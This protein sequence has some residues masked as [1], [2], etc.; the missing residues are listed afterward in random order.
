MALKRDETGAPFWEDADVPPGFMGSYHIGGD[1]WRQR[2]RACPAVH[3]SQ[4]GSVPRYRGIGPHERAEHGLDV[5][6]INVGI[7]A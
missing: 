4:N 3:D 6:G 5:A 1:V 2:C 7:L